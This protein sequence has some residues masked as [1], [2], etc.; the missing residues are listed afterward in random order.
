MSYHSN[1][2]KKES[3]L[4]QECIESEHISN[5]GTTHGRESGELPESL[6]TE[7]MLACFLKSKLHRVV[8]V[9]SGQ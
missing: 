5:I 2:F 6:G 1:S 7:A 8:V 3:V 4:R 9:L